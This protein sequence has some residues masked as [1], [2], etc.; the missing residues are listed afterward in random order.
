MLR[1]YVQAPF[2][3]FRTFTA[4]WYRPT[5]GFLTPSAAYGLALNLAGIETRRDDGSAMTVTA[6][7]LPRA[8]IALGA[9]PDNPRGPYPTVHTI[10]QQLHNYPVGASG[11][12]RKE[13]AKGNKYN[14]TPVRREFL[15]DLRAIVALDFDETEEYPDVE[16]RIRRALDRD[17]PQSRRTYGLPFLGDNAFLID[18]IEICEE[19]RTA[20]WYCRVRSHVGAVPHSTRLTTWIDRRDM[21]RTRSDLFAPAEPAGESIPDDAWTAIEPPPEPAPVRTSKKK[22]LP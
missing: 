16:G 18:K 3:A 1:L 11:K 6:F 2:A 14:I 15:S 17:A 22:G 8:R 21:S 5:A 4:G 9:D 7:G 12:A 13:D 10:Y 19:P 20:L